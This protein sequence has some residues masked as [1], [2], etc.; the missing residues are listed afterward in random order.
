MYVLHYLCAI[1]QSIGLFTVVRANG[2]APKKTFTHT[3]A[4][5]SS[6]KSTFKHKIEFEIEF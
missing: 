5:F 4:E 3:Y 6:I 1:V 2:F